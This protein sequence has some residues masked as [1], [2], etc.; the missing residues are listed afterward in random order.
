V[1]YEV[2]WTSSLGVGGSLGTVARTTVMPVRVGEQQALN[3]SGG[4]EQ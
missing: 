1:I 2:F 4:T 3:E